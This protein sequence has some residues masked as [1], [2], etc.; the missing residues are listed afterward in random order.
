M[1]KRYESKKKAKN[2]WG[3][4]ITGEANFVEEALGPE[5]RNFTPM[6]IEKE[7]HKIH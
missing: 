7:T 6:I 2:C 3:L 5:P 4:K 1:M